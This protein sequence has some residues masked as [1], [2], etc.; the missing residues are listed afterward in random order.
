MI[1]NK[2]G[3]G[4]NIAADFVAH[5]AADGYTLLMDNS[6][7]PSDQ[8]KQKPGGQQETN[9]SPQ[10]DFVPVTLLGTQG[11]HPRGQSGCAGAFAERVDRALQGAARQDQFRLVWLWRGRASRG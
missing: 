4:G 6:I 3:A 2:P 5:A 8:L 1:E 7:P 9:Y 10:K 11:K